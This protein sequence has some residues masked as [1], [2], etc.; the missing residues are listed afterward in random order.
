M[1]RSVSINSADTSGKAAR[2]PM[3]TGSRCSRPNM[4]GAVTTR[5]PLGSMYSPAAVR[6]ASFSCSRMVLAAVTYERPAGVRSSPLAERINR[7]A[8]RWLSNSET[9]RLTV[10][11]GT[12]SLRLALERLPHS[13]AAS[14]TAIASRRSTSLP[15]PG[16]HPHTLAATL[17]KREGPDGA[18]ARRRDRR[19]ACHTDE[20]ARSRSLW[21]VRKARPSAEDGPSHLGQLEPNSRHSGLR[22]TEPP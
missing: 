22:F 14:I 9:L 12:P 13:T 11:S 16:N 15:D 18:F 7:S 1:T 21:T 3:T 8:L 6:S 2:K 17:R 4:V 10:A 19:F 20:K 5:S